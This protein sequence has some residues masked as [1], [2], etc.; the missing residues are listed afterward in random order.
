MKLHF[1]FLGTAGELIIDGEETSRYPPLVLV[2]FGRLLGP[3]D[4]NSSKHHSRDA[5]YCVRGPFEAIPPCV[6]SAAIPHDFT[7]YCVMGIKVLFPW[8]YER[9]HFRDESAESGD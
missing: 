2:Y 3:R 6:V 9:G 1:T 4:N 5:T 7:R 8:Y